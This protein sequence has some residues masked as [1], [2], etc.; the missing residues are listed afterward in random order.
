MAQTRLVHK[1]KP[2]DKGFLAETDDLWRKGLFE[3]VGNFFNETERLNKKV[4][5]G[6]AHESSLT[7]I[8]PNTT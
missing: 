6:L 2:S 1:S 3:K 4:Q 5:K 7:K 8:I